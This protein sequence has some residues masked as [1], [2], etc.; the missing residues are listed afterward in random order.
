MKI[1]DDVWYK[2]NRADDVI[3]IIMKFCGDC[4]DVKPENEF[5]KC[6]SLRDGLQVRCKSCAAARNLQ[7][8]RTLKGALSRLAD[9]AKSNA[10]TRGKSGRDEAAVCTIVATDLQHIWD[11]QEGKCYYSGVPMSTAPGLWHVSLE[12]LE[13]AQGYVLENVVLV[14]LVCNTPRKWSLDAVKEFVQEHLSVDRLPIALQEG[15]RIR[16]QR[17]KMLEDRLIEGKLFSFCTRCE[18]FQLS[19]DFGKTKQHGCA[20]CRLEIRTE[21]RDTL[22]GLMKELLSSA[23]QCT[24]KRNLNKNRTSMDFDITREDLI[25]LLEKQG[26]RCAISNIPLAYGPKMQFSA[27]LDR[28]DVEVGYVKGNVQLV[29]AI[30]N[31]MDNTAIQKDQ[32]GVWAW[33]EERYA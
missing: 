12:R 7:R 14:C 18:S 11:T 9:S 13:P 4:S 10:K 26:G 32:S 29:A 3:D 17:T 28:K 6:V 24:K 5:S 16:K 8:R 20:Q 31:P 23:R 19:S 27:S 33:T 25:K 1:C 21:R 22:N 2:D 30:L 15:L